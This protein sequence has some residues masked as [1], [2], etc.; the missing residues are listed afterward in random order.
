MNTP[1]AFLLV[2]GSL[3]TIAANIIVMIGVVVATT[4]ASIGVV[5]ESP[6]IKQ[7]WLKVI[8]SNDAMKS[9]KEVARRNFLVGNKNRGYPESYGSSCNTHGGECQP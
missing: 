6:M 4:V 7:L 8:E 3:R 2:R 5:Y 9:K 1:N